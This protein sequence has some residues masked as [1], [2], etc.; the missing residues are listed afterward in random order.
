MRKPDR[1]E[2]FTTEIAE[3]WRRNFP[4][5]RFGQFISNVFG[6]IRSKHGDIFFFEE[7]KMLEYFKEYTRDYCKPLPIVI[8]SDEEILITLD[9]GTSDEFI[10]CLCKD[11]FSLSLSMS[12]FIDKC[13]D[14]I[15]FVS[16]NSVYN[17]DN[18]DRST[19]ASL[20]IAF[21]QY[22]ADHIHD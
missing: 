19:K 11:Q 13:R 4:D 2:P 21:A 18:L 3:I 17:F 7:D 6:W 5:W 22:F 20:D 15:Q 14:D 9:G 1:I 12:E 16:K 10:N 8:S